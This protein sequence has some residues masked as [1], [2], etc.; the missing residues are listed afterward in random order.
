M[1]NFSIFNQKFVLSSQ[2]SMG[3]IRDPGSGKNLTQI[4]GPDPWVKKLSDP[5]SRSATLNKTVITLLINADNV[6]L[7][8]GQH[9]AGG[10]AFQRPGG[11]L[12]Y[13]R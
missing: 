4:P 11:D 5:G 10:G 13:C 1:K 6:L 8:V 12:R 7:C 9:P 3:W 2:N